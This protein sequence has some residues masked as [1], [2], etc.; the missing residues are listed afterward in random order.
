M[1]YI[2]ERLPVSVLEKPVIGIG[3]LIF[4]RIS[5]S[6]EHVKRK[7]NGGCKKERPVRRSIK[8]P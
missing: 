8:S 6:I 3:K 4:H 1:N 5:Q 2:T 7:S